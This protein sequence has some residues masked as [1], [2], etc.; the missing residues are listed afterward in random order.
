MLSDIIPFFIMGLLG[1]IKIRVLIDYL[2]VNFVGFTTTFNQIFGYL[3]LA[4]AGFG[5][6]IVFALYTPV[7][8]RNKKKV[9]QLLSGARIVFARIGVIILIVGFILSFFVDMMIKK[10]PVDP[11]TT[12]ILFIIFLITSTGNYFIFAPRFLL[13][14]DQ[15]KYMINLVTNGT[16][17]LQ[18]LVEIALLMLG[19]GLMTIFISYFIIMFITNVI[20]NKL[21][22]REYPWIKLNV[23]PDMSTVANTK[24]VFV[25]R[26]G[27][28]VALNTDSIMLAA[29]VGTDVAG[30]YAAYNYIAQFIISI[31]SK[32]INATQE[33]FGHF[34]A[35]KEKEEGVNAY[36]EMNAFL[37]FIASIIFTVTYLSVNDFIRLWVGKKMLVSQFTVLLFSAVFFYRIVRGTSMVIVN[38]IGAFKETKWQSLFE[39]LLNLILSIILVQKYSINGVLISTVIAYLL[40]GFWFVPNYI[41]QKVFH[42]NPIAYYVNYFVNVVI[43]VVVLYIVQ[44]LCTLLG[45]YQNTV[46]LGGWFL[47]TII[48]TTIVSLIYFVIYYST[49]SHFRLLVDR[50]KYLVVRRRK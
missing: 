24:H 34:F 6:A 37:F 45:F 50:F 8:K 38:G 17:I 46:H 15:N 39:G 44:K 22:Y 9:N 41:F 18:I 29:F 11:F 47:D 2:G 25:Q 19:F 21:A 49:Y 26:I 10:N 36:W 35:S 3:N 42:K 4:E 30:I 1:F 20:I 33:S 27:S 28:I 31:T 14:A 32:I 12:Q 5:T 48:F 40:T 16:R 7:I 43:M 13:Q 23:R